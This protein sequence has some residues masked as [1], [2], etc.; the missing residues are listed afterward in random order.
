MYWAS[1]VYSI[2]ELHIQQEIVL[3]VEELCSPFSQAVVLKIQ[4]LHEHMKLPYTESEP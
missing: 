1:K 2:V 4:W 3:Y